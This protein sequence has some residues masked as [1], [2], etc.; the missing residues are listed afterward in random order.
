[1]ATTREER[2][3]AFGQCPSRTGVRRLEKHLQQ[4]LVRA[5]KIVVLLFTDDSRYCSKEHAFPGLGPV[6]AFFAFRPPGTCL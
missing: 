5:A 3:D 2:S 6:T 1:V 4:L